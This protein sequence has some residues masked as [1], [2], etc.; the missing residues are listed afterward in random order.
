MSH[1]SQFSRSRRENKALII[2]HSTHVAVC[3]WINSKDLLD[4]DQ[5]RIMPPQSMGDYEKTSQLL[6]K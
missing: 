2:R 5:A 4:N 6:I 1:K 3:N